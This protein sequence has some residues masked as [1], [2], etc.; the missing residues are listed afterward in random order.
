V[1]QLQPIAETDATVTLHRADYEAL[2][3]AI[4]DAADLA[5]VARH[6]AYEERVGWEAA[7]RSYLLME[8][9]ERSSRQKS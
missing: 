6:R 8:E 5:A 4:G 2:L 1:K 7:R 9:A 3:D